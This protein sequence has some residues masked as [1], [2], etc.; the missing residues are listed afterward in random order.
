MIRNT[1]GLSTLMTNNL[2]AYRSYSLG[3]DAAE[4]LRPAEAIA[5]FNKAVQLDPDFAMAQARIGYTY[6][7]S[8]DK[9]GDGRPYLERAFRLS[10]RL[11]EKDRLDIAAWYAI[12]NLDFAG[13]IRAEREIISKYPD[14]VETYTQLGRL[15]AG[16]DRYDE[17]IA[18]FQ[19]SLNVD[20]DTPVTHNELRAAYSYLG[21]HDAAIAEA[22]R[23]VALAP[24]EPNAVDSLGYSYQIAERYPE[25]EASYRRA[26]A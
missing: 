6:A 24:A 16:E 9:P 3:L 14:D 17:A 5:L 23:F 19:R 1:V 13:A 2:E 21:K 18:V 7:A 8:W 22:E 11:T 15:L 10:K 4:G 12:A 20:P 26:L 25:A